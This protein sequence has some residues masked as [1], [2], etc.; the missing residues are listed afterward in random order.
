M[1]DRLRFRR[2]DP[3]E[4]QP[5]NGIF[6]QAARLVIKELYNEPKP[7]DSYITGVLEE[8]RDNNLTLVATRG[9]DVT[10]VISTSVDPANPTVGTIEILVVDNNFRY[11]GVGT[12]LTRAALRLIMCQ[13]PSLD[14]IKLVAVTENGQEIFYT[15][16][17][18][19]PYES[20][21]VGPGILPMSASVET[22][23]DTLKF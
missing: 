13:N 17:G 11:N 6:G 12:K 22:L 19:E 4:F 8:F 23:R 3:A 9:K 2:D 16:L 5:V 10:G 20:E 18:F 21:E 1:S 14:T 15:K 7:H